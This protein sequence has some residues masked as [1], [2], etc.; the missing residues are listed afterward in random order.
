MRSVNKLRCAQSYQ[1]KLFI[2]NI[3]YMMLMRQLVREISNLHIYV[4]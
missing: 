2:M 4:S 1:L 3:N